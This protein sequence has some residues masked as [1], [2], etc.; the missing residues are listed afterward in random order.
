MPRCVIAVG[1]ALAALCAPAQAADPGRWAF[2]GTSSMPLYYYQ[3][4]PPTP[5]AAVLRRGQHRPLPH[6]LAAPRAGA[7]RRRDPADRDGHRGLQPHRR[8]QLGRG[9]ARADHPAGLECYYPPAGNTC[10]TGSFGVAD[11]ETLPGATT[12]TSTRPSSRRPCGP[13]FTDGR[14][15]WTSSGDDLLG[16]RA[17]DVK[18]SHAAPGGPLLKPSMRLSG[19]VP[20]TGTR[21]RRSTA[22][23]CTWRARTATSSRSGR[24]TSPPARG[25]WRSSARSS[26]SPRASPCSTRSAASCTGRCS[27]TT[28]RA[29]P[30]TRR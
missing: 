28:S 11:P 26:G 9:R 13:S 17:K 20:P 16:Y 29:C 8:H 2:T 15:I 6:R 5:R 22:A 24:S 14:T 4:S 23:G 21:A 30:P 10:G 7:Q 18:P 1:L 3:G 19:A 12:S 25:S 27:P